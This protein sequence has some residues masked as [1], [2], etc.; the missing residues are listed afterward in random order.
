MGA[1]HLLHQVSKSSPKF[2]RRFTGDYFCAD[3]KSFHKGGAEL[4][5]ATVPNRGERLRKPPSHPISW[6]RA[7]IEA[8]TL[9]RQFAARPP[10]MKVERELGVGSWIAQLE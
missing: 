9:N 6:D 3:V 8:T 10:R 5:L 4:T 7:G 2:S 1:G